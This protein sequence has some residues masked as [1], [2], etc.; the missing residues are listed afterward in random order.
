MPKE[1]SWLLVY[2]PL[3]NMLVSLDDA[4]YMW[5]HTHACSS[6]HLPVMPCQDVWSEPVSTTNQPSPAMLILTRARPERQHARH[7]ICAELI[8]LAEHKGPRHSHILLSKILNER[9]HTY[10]RKLLNCWIIFWG[11]FFWS[12]VPFNAKQSLL[13]T[14]NQD[15]HSISWCIIV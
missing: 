7:K 6:H 5:K 3:S 14:Q 8:Y 2:L 10:H 9:G 4:Q 12:C 13:K 1:L 11:T 15:L